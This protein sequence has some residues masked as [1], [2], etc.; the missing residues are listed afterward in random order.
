MLTTGL[1]VFIET[2]S[3]L[4]PILLSLLLILL[5]SLAINPL[6]TR[7]RS[8]TGGRAVA[9]ALLA[10]SFLVLIALM[11]LAFYRPVK[12]SIIQLSENL[13]DYWDRLRKP[14]IRMERQ[15][16]IAEA[17][18]E[19]QVSHEISQ[20]DKAEGKP[21]ALRTP[22]GP[23][24]QK[25]LKE[26]E[27]LGSSLAR[28]LQ[29]T[30]SSF[31]AVTF[32]AAHIMVVL[33][34][35]FFGVLFTLMNPRP[36]FSAI[37]SLIPE[38]HHVQALVIIQR[39][40]T[41]VPVWAW[42]TLLGMLTIGTLVFLLMWPIF[43]FMDAMALGLIAGILEAIPYLGPF[44][45]AAAGLLL[46]LGKGGMTPVWVLLAYAAVQALENNVII[47]IIMSR[48]MKLHPM[49]LIFS[50]L[51]CVAAFGVLG[52]LIAAPAAAI[53]SILHEELY[54]KQFLPSVTDAQLDRLARR[55]LSEKPSLPQ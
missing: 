20:T 49:T 31:T 28:M 53:L 6:I 17:K 48:S 38:N 12:T 5:I 39:I 55:A 41:F 51:F 44:L 2:F 52:V 35:V 10:G 16:V 1:F 13:P 50:T 8:F 29:T 9:T 25:R 18:L 26:S 42:A 32:N 46:S 23:A 40:G 33:V 36:I 45:S 37:F 43:G 54:R 11:G 7:M 47:P 30:A 27:T 34:T 3:L 4:S 15:A 22:A 14:L 19:A 21:E 24:P